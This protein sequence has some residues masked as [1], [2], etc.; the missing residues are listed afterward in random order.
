M[1]KLY[2]KKVSGEMRLK[3]IKIWTK[4]INPCASRIRKTVFLYLSSPYRQ[5]QQSWG[6]LG[7]TV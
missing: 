3:I 4:E 1:H 7:P 6:F 5:L 2:K